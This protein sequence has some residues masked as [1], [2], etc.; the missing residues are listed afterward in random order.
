M[1]LELYEVWVEE[2]Q[3]PEL[4]RLP[5]NF[6]SDVA[7]YI[8]RLRDESRMLD[9][10]TVKA[11]LLRKEMMNVRRMVQQ[12]VRA[13]YKKLV[14]KVASGEK[15]S[16]NILTMEEQKICTSISPFHEAFQDLVKNM[17]R[18]QEP[19]ANDRKQHKKVVLRFLKDVPP[20]VGSDMLTYGPF[21]IEDV[22]SLPVENAKI[23]IKQGLAKEI[24]ID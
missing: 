3:N 11:S 2:L 1:Y 22:A 12:V 8:K 14:R 16:S 18:G 24:E 21:K 10:K 20:V 9:K 13:R 5:S 4:A 23:F 7:D 6:Y 17:L 19:R 15:P